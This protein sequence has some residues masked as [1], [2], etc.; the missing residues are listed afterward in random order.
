M[1]FEPHIQ[2]KSFSDVSLRKPP[3]GPLDAHFSGLLE[4]AFLEASLLEANSIFQASLLE[5]SL[6]AEESR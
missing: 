3:E 6:R 4:A 1:D 2:Y 5:A